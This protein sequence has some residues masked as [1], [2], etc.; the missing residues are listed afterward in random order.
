MDIVNAYRIILDFD[1]HKHRPVVS[2]VV[3]DQAFV[4][5]R[6]S[7]KDSHSI[8]SFFGVAI[9]DVI[10]MFVFPVLAQVLDGIVG[11]GSM[12][13]EKLLKTLDIGG[14]ITH[15]LKCILRSRFPLLFAPPEVKEMGVIAQ[16][17]DPILSLFFLV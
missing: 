16:N 2:L 9:D 11:R 13:L 7:A 1:I 4:D 5:D 6:I 12:I 3:E 8:R 14:M 10:S 17:R 15:P